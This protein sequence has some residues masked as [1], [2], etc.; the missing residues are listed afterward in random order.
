MHKLENLIQDLG[1]LPHPE[2]GWYKEVYRSEDRLLK[3]GLPDR[4]PGDRVAST[5]IYF[6]ISSDNFSAFHR[7]R[8]DEGWHF[9]AGKGLVVYDI[10]PLG[11]LSIHRLGPDLAS[12]E[13]FQAWIPAG[14]WFA[15]R[16]E[17]TAGF[18]LVGCTVAPGF[19]FEDFDM[20]ERH[21]LLDLF[22]QHSTLIMELTRPA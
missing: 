17:Q 19:E 11:K 12:G 1:L 16:V 20:A 9:Y 7:I 22:P 14:H 8:G 10:S 3:A 13:T 15:S 18:A 6:L 4:F 5:G 2:G 21:A